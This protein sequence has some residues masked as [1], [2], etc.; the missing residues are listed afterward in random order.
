MQDEQR[1][2]DEGLE[3]GERELRDALASLRPTRPGIDIA[4]IA[5]A[6][7]RAAERRRVAFWRAAAGALAACLGLV[8]WL[9]RPGPPVERVVVV[10]VP[11]ASPAV[12]NPTMVSVATHDTSAPLSF[13]SSPSRIDEAE[14]SDDAYLAT[15]Q[16]VLRRGLSGLLPPLALVKNM[17]RSAISPEP[18]P[19]AGPLLQTDSRGPIPRLLKLMEK[20]A[21]L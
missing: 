2:N 6:G 16:R 17:D 20:G 4:G 3:G 1:I 8:L 12:S 10:K 18:S 13:F 15:R 21:Q 7:A 9:H 19:T 11:T 14:A 5:I